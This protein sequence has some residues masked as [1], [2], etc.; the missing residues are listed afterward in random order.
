MA[1][2]IPVGNG[3]VLVAFDRDYIL[4]EFCFPHVGEENHAAGFPFRLGAWVNGEFS[5]LSEEWK[6]TKDYIDD[7]L[8]T[9]VE[10]ENERLK[11]RIVA[12]DLVDFH[13]N[14][15]LKKLTVENLS[16]E[17]QDVRLFLCQDFHISGNNV[18]D[19]AAFKPEVDGV[20]HYKGRRYFLVNVCANG[21]CGVDQFA[22][23]HKEQ[24]AAEGTWRDAEDGILGGNP[25]AQGSVD[26]VVAVHIQ[27]EPDSKDTCFYWICA[28]KNWGEV[29]ELNQTI[30]EKGPETILK[31]TLDY[32]KL[33]ADK[34]ELN[35]LSTP[36]EILLK[37]TCL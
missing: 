1:R 36:L 5:W 13:K 23:G 34:E 19:T 6:I 14:I 37:R 27:L 35:L 2:D 12:N 20:L 29:H 26:S 11:I 16:D 18:G 33:W 7:T 24:N 8:V 31:R 10:L 30:W 17:A 15:Y 22:I 25:I 3:S 21:K 28:G 32:W 9:N 4:R